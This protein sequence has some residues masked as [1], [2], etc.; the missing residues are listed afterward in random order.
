MPVPHTARSAIT[1]RLGARL[2]LGAMLLAG[3][4]IA[5]DPRA[6]LPEDE[7]LYF[8][9]PDRFENADTANDRGGL[10]GDRLAT[11]FDP[12]HKG[13]YHGGDLKGLTQRLDYIE[14]LGATSIWVGPIYK[15]KPVQGPAGHESAGYHGYWIT[16]FTHVDPHLGTNADFLG[17]VAAAHARGIKVY[18]DIV[19][20]H[21][22]DVIRYR[23]CPDNNC[24]YRSRAEYPYTRRGGLGGPPINDGF[25]GD[26]PAYQTDENFSRLTRPDYAY[27]PYVPPGEEHVKAPEWLN[28]LI[29]YH[30]RGSS[31][32]RGESSEAGDFGGLDDLFTQNPRVVRGF[33]EIYGD[34]IEKFGVDGFRVDT[35]KHVN[36]EFWQQFVPAMLERARRTGIPH[37][38]LFGE[39]ATDQLDPALLAEHTRNSHFPADLDFAFFAAVRD[40]VAGEA[41]TEE[42]ARMFAADVL[43]EGGEAAALRLPTFVSNHDA[44]RFAYFVHRAR[45]GAPDAEVLAR[46]ILAHAMLL[47]LRGVPVIYYGDEQGFAGSGGDQDARQ[48]MFATQVASYRNEVR[49]GTG[50]KGDTASFNAHHP[51]F[52]AISEL[53]RLRRSQPALTRGRQLVRSYAESPG[54]FAV[55]RFE[56]GS[57]RELVVAFN[58]STAPISTHVQVEPTSASF[59]S[60]HGSCARTPSAPESYPLVLPPLAFVVC[61]TGAAR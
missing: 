41:P 47:T 22:A 32:F 44:G 49:V 54:L 37:F 16:D 15:N 20:N 59:E 3:P 43:Y 55:S 48:D 46:V 2:A 56:P 31:S 9:L 23:E 26:G 42:L 61:A 24:P 28:D 7:I 51:L 50:V 4:A 58:T 39:A 18:L 34:W 1:T 17:L 30:N 11:G 53:A 35:A 29:Y 38:H 13:F 27:T 52:V 14:A 45:P 12:A 36:P 21:T 6:R 5:D 33:I 40:T 10:N 57:G 60:L 25:M 8:V 19:T